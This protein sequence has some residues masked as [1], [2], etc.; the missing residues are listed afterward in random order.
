MIDAMP[1]G[2][3]DRWV[4]AVDV[5]KLFPDRP[6]DTAIKALA[7]RMGQGRLRTGAEEARI[8]GIPHLRYCF[9]NA[10]VWAAWLYDYDNDF[11]LTGD[12]SVPWGLDDS[13]QPSPTGTQLFDV[14]F[15]PAGLVQM[16]AALPVD[17]EQA[18][19]LERRPILPVAEQRRCA[20]M[21]ANLWGTG[22]TDGRAWELAKG[23]NPAHSVPRDPFLG[24]LREFTGPRSRGR[25]TT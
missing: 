8:H 25:P 12:T 14:R 6:R 20:E 22:V 9:L 1:E 11:W 3:F 21:I 19:T 24:I 18:V 23:M 2:E 15:E 4:K 17:P 10:A 5:L 7:V 16:G 13:Y